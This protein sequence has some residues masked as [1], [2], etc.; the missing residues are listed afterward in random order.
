MERLKEHETFLCKVANT[1]R[2]ADVQLLIKGAKVGELD[3]ICEVILNILNGVIPL[4]KYFVKKATKY[5]T[6]LRRL[7]KRCLKKLLRKKM[8]IK[9]F[10]IIR[11]IVAAVLPVC[12][13]IGSLL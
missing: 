5:K 13:V 8:L 6:I 9:Y 7:A 1:K 10:T 11:D 3:I 4:S 12:G 2:K